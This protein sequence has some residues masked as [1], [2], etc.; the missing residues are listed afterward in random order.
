MRASALRR[1]TNCSRGRLAA[2]LEGIVPGLLLSMHLERLDDVPGV[3][4]ILRQLRPEHLDQLARPIQVD[5]IRNPDLKLVDRRVAAHVLHGPEL[6]ERHR[7][8][9]SAVMPQ[10]HRAQREG[11]NCTLVGAVLEVL[12][13]PERVVEQVEGPAGHILQQCMGTEAR[14]AEYLGACGQLTDLKPRPGAAVPH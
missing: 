5:V 14:H 13:D 6:A 10:L 3:L 1:L 7:V 9:R 2:D 11:L 4:R 12:A 8:D